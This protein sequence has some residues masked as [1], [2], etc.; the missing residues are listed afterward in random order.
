MLREEI[1][2]NIEKD[3]RVDIHELA[4]RLGASDEEVGS[5]MKQMEEEGIKF[6]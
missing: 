3:S 2:K 6:E 5:Q 4:V 1:L